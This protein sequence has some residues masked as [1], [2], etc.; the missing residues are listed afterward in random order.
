MDRL[1]HVTYCGLYC[2][3]CANIARI[4]RQAQALRDTLHKEGWQHYGESVVAGFNQFLDVLE[5]FSS[6]DETCPG[7]RGG[8]GFPGCE[9]RACAQERDLEVCSACED[10]PCDRIRE[11]GRAYPN[12]IADGMRQSQIGL[13]AW[14]EEQEERCATGFA[15][16]DIR[17]PDVDSD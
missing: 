7:C 6:Y 8:C 10:F 15:Y 3:L 5:H 14:I 4:P 1:K 9:I 16:A 13:D 17:C 12:L 11:L 2:K